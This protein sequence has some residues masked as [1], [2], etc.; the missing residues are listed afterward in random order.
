MDDLIR[1]IL[2]E[3]GGS[4]EAHAPG[5]AWAA[6][7]LESALASTLASPASSAFERV[8]I[9]QAFGAALGSALAQELAGSLAPRLVKQV[10]QVLAKHLEQAMATQSPGRDRPG[11]GDSNSAGSGRK[12]GAR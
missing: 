1:A 9:A 2:Q 6:S 7:L 10:E 8:L 3:A 4:P 5:K 11:A 12:P